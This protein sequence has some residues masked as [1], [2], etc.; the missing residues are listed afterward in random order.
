MA[1]L[2]YS[3]LP[4]CGKEYAPLVVEEGTVVFYQYKSGTVQGFTHIIK[5]SQNTLIQMF[6]SSP[7]TGVEDK[8]Y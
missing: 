1:V 5:G 3:S 2:A 4:L 8:H 6:I 7:T